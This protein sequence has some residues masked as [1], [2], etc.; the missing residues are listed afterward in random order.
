[1][2]QNPWL[3][4]SQKYSG[5]YGVGLRLLPNP[6]AGTSNAETPSDWKADKVAIDVAPSS[7]N[8]TNVHPM[9]FPSPSGNGYAGPYYH[10]FAI[11]LGNSD[12]G[13]FPAPDT[14]L[15][16]WQAWQGGPWAPPA[17]LQVIKGQSSTSNSLKVQLWIRNDT[18]GLD[19]FATPPKVAGTFT[20]NK[21]QWYRIVIAM[22]PS[23]TS[24]GDSGGF[25]EVWV[26]GSRKI[27]YRDDWGYKPASA[28]GDGMN[29]FS[30]Q[31]LLY[32][33]RS[34]QDTRLFL[35]NCKFGNSFNQVNP[36]SSASATS[37]S[38]S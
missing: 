33:S 10:G 36:P 9:R 37:G 13:Y 20:M 35:D 6:F 5:S 19:S 3:S 22:R 31:L 1:M 14:D 11:Q 17:C 25:L 34:A 29:T 15:M 21:G 27:N 16:I 24:D 8:S 38:S 32:R 30:A 12:G 2:D 7:V 28:G 4:P 26:D 23:W 18:I